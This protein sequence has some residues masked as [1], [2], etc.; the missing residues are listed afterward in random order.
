MIFLCH[1]VIYYNLIQTNTQ[2]NHC[3]SK[4]QFTHRTLNQLYNPWLIAYL[5]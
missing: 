3:G 2:V 5:P 1:A 4:V